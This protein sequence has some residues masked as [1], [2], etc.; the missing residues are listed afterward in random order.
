M[1]K[2]AFGI[3]KNYYGSIFSAGIVLIISI[4][5]SMFYYNQIYTPD[6]NLF[7]FS[8]YRLWADSETYRLVASR[9][10]ERISDLMSISSNYLGPVL[11]YKILDMRED[12]V[13]AFNIAC[14][15]VSFCIARF[16]LGLPFLSLGFVFLNPIVILSLFFI[17][18]EI[19]LLLSVVCFLFFLKRGDRL[20]VATSIFF[21]FL[22]RWQVGVLGAVVFIA[23]E[24]F[25]RLPNIRLGNL[26]LFF[27]NNTSIIPTLLGISIIC[28]NFAYPFI[29]KDSL[30]QFVVGLESSQ[31]TARL[32]SMQEEFMFVFAL[33]PKIFIN[34]FGNPFTGFNSMAIFYEKRNIYNVAVVLSQYTNLLLA[35]L[36]LWKGKIGKSLYYSSTYLYVGLYIILFSATPFTQTRYF[37]PLLP[38]IC[39]LLLTAPQAG[40]MNFKRS[41]K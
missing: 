20:F 35:L 33:F 18:K 32:S 23:I 17:N 38:A 22:W 24:I 28:M 34:F 37:I 16:G 8:E 29:P 6:T 10:Y 1:T 7:A 27:R 5:A 9:S 4:V 12:L 14:Y 13:F 30:E 39:A 3:K 21:G 11:L 25:A 19:P 2:L 36:I 31:M 41:K 15:L 40:I 26:V